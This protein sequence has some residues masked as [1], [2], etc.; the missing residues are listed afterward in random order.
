M[1]RGNYRIT[2]LNLDTK[3]QRVIAVLAVF[4]YSTI[5]ERLQRFHPTPIVT[6]DDVLFNAL[7]YLLG[8]LAYLVM[9]S[10]CWSPPPRTY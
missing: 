7:R 5:L 9:A 2:H 6:L 3:W 8:A 10:G 1:I 4:S